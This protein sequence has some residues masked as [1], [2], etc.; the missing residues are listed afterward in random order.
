MYCC[1]TWSSDLVTPVSSAKRNITACAPGII[2]SV[3]SGSVP[4]AFNPGVSRITRP[5]LSKGCGKL[6][7]A[8]RQQGI[9][10]LPPL[11][12]ITVVVMN[13]DS[14]SKPSL[15]ASSTVTVLTSARLDIVLAISSC[16]STSS[17]IV[18]HSPGLC[19]SAPILSSPVRLSIG[20]RRT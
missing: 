8:C 7:I 20:N 16:D 19:L 9:S 3:S 14:S 4:S 17:L 11:C 12:F 5:F 13:S 15:S 10:T 18:T 2:D 1:Q 6:I